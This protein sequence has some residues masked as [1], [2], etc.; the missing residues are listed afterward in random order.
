MGLWGAK[1]EFP[2]KLYSHAKARPR[3]IGEMR[4]V[5]RVCHRLP[6]YLRTPLTAVECRTMVRL[7]LE[8]RERDFLNLMR[9]AVFNNPNSPYQPLMRLAGCEYSDLV[10]LI[11]RE[12]LE[13]TLRMLL[14]WE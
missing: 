6:A 2:M 5:L 14:L 9:G 11:H 4:I 8:Q 3:I 10:K 7:R 1:R 13:Q 12:G